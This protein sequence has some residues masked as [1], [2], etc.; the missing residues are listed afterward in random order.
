MR[1]FYSLLLALIAL[2][3]QAQ[4]YNFATF[5]IANSA[6][7]S[8]SINDLEEDAS[9]NIWIATYNGASVF[10]GTGFTNYAT[11]NSAIGSNFLRKVK[12]DNLG[13][14]W[15]ATENNGITRLNGNTWTTYNTNNSGLPVNYIHDIAIDSQ[16]VLWVATSSG[17]SRFSGDTWVTYNGMSS[18]NSVAIDSNNGVWVV[19]DSGVLCKFTGSSFT[20]IQQGVNEILKIKNNTV[21]VAGSDSLMTFS[22]AGTFLSAYY[23]S[24]SCI[25][26]WST[27][28]LDVSPANKV[29]LSLPGSGIQNFT[30][31]TAYNQNNSPLPDDYFT[32]ILTASN[33]TVWVGHSQMGLVKMSVATNACIA[34]T[35]FSSAYIT[36]TSASINWGFSASA[37]SYL[38]VYNTVPT[39]GG[40]DGSTDGL[41]ANLFELTPNTDY[42]WWV[43]SVCGGVQSEWA[44]GGSF[45]T[46]P[47]ASNGCFKQIASGQQFTMAIKEDGTL[48]SWGANAYGQLGYATTSNINVPTQV[49]TASNWKSISCGTAH[50]L[51]IKQDGT[52]WA[53]GNNFYG[54]LGDGTTTTRVTPVQIGTATNWKTVAAGNTHSLAVKTDGTLWAWGYNAHGQL[55]VGSTTNKSVPTQVGI[56]TDWNSVGGGN[57]HSFGIKTNGTLWAWGRNNYGQVGDGTQVSRTAPFQ[58]GT[59]TNWKLAD[60]GADFS[61]AVK[62]DGTLWT[63]GYNASGQLGHNDLNDRLVPTKVG[64]A[65]TWEF[66]SAGTSHVLASRNYGALFAWGNNS[67]GQL[68]LG[69]TVSV[70][71]PSLLLNVD[72]WKAVAA[73]FDFSAA[74]KDNGLVHSFGNNSLGQLGNNSFTNDLDVFGALNCPTANLSTEPALT[75]Q[76]ISIWPNPVTDMLTIQTEQPITD[77]ALFNILG[78]QVSKPIITDGNRIS[79]ANLT[80]GT[81]MLKVICGQNTQ[82]MKVVKK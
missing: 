62:T 69:N 1:H 29:W 45:T 55:G 7:G 79:L 68:G 6:I 16:N 9:G 24:N 5:N 11:S 2:G 74:L 36:S 22:T 20:V 61:V 49:G 67:E 40:M 33:G 35:T 63:W 3:T 10:N 32:S 21:Y 60:G 27:N 51:A 77:I 80:A 37:T 31:C 58:I 26:G 17:L 8:N 25:S 57:S 53:W 71:S 64:T 46:L 13:R 43:A 30:D 14:K 56:S 81:Y 28:A 59:N 42:H 82:T 50:T 52:L 76:N 70:S 41:N 48:W 39:I 78:Q 54:Y 19:S 38:Y 12:I 75:L 15:F 23:Q 65:T 4:S 18:I 72:A 73:G 47:G 34:P 66:A 44:Y